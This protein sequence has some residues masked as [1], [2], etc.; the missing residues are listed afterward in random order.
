VSANCFSFWRR[1]PPDPLTGLRPWT[2]LGTIVPQTPWAIVPLASP[3]VVASV[4]LHVDR[5]CV[6][7][8][9][10]C[11]AGQVD[12]RVSHTL[13]LALFFCVSS[14]RVSTAFCTGAA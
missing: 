11:I 3:L 13:H 8:A 2:P 4:W 9:F 1:S 7:T 10:Y 12:E 14:Q 5:A 6:I